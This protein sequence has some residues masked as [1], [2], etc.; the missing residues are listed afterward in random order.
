MVETTKKEQFIELRAK[1]L[2]FSK[3]SEQI[4]VSKPTLINW[5]KDL[6][7]EVAN[8]KAVELEALQ[9]QYFV[10]KKE[11]IKLLGKQLS[12]ICD[13]LIARKDLVELTTKELLQLQIVYV[14]A[15]R[16]EEV[17]VEFEIEEEGLKPINFNDTTKW[18]A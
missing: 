4:S 7:Q 12:S 14:K 8:L 5:S 9:E 18:V 11:R 6:Q 15:L 17:V 16:D 13:E 1:N 2:S 10:T 3:I